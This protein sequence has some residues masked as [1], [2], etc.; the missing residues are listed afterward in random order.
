MTTREMTLWG[1]K[2]D[3]INGFEIIYIDTEINWHGKFWWN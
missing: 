3:L 2:V 1:Y